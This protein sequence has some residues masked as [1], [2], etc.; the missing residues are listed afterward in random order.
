MWNGWSAVNTENFIRNGIMEFISFETKEDNDELNSLSKD[1]E[2][3]CCCFMVN[4]YSFSQ[5]LIL[6]QALNRQDFKRI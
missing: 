5:L 2:S 4:K 3:S 1:A 6:T